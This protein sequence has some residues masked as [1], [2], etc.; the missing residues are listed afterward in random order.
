MAWKSVTLAIH[1]HAVSI[2]AATAC[3]SYRTKQGHMSVHGR[4]VVALV[5]P[6]PMLLL[7]YLQCLLRQRTHM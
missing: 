3:S 4:Q 6:D 5:P 2:Q 1:H 7:D